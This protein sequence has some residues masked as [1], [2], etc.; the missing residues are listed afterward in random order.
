MNER[1]RAEIQQ[2]CLNRQAAGSVFIDPESIA[3]AHWTLFKCQY[4]CPA[5]NKSLCCPPHAPSHAETQKIIAEYTVA[6]LVYFRGEVPVTKTIAE[7]ERAVFLKNY[8]K[9]IGFGA[10]P[11]KLCTECSLDGCLFPYQARPSMEA[12]GIDVYSTVRDNGFSLNVLT[13]RD[14]QRNSF[15]LLLIE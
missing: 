7:I 2:I 8:Y 10:G 15:G 1:D 5:F 13:S 14:E 3:M 9:V 6:L 11:C 12:C 4:G